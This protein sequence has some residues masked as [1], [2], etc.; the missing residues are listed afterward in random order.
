MP[1]KKAQVAVMRTRLSAA[2][3]LLSGPGAFCQDPGPG[4]YEQQ[5]DARRSTRG[6]VRSLGRLGWKVTP[7][8]VD[9]DTGEVTA[10]A[11]S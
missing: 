10:P 4:Y 11:A 3:A 2:H 5:A 9:P 8:P 1:E 7:E 6:H